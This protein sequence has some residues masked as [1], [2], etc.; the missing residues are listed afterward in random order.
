MQSRSWRTTYVCDSKEQRG[1]T[2]ASPR[3]IPTVYLNV[4]VPYLFFAFLATV[5]FRFFPGLNTG[6]TFAG[7][8]SF[9]P[10]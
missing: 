7:T 8:L 3:G 9:F 5:V 2:G 4:L 10:V 1:K 6:T